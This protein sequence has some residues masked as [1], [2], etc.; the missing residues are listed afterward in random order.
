MLHLNSLN[1]ISRIRKDRKR[2]IWS[3]DSAFRAETLDF[4]VENITHLTM[5]PKRPRL[6]PPSKNIIVTEATGLQ[7][8][9]LMTV[10]SDGT[11]PR[12]WDDY[13]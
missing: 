13:K 1:S 5:S 4:T 7:M 10:D 6:E 2:S 9:T 3:A 12:V 8:S 11:A